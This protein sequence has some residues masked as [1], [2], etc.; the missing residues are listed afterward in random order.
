M[1]IV[2]YFILVI[3]LQIHIDGSPTIEVKE[4]KKRRNQIKVNH[5]NAFHFRIKCIKS[6]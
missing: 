5:F 6:G 2:P 4:D 1:R 3:C